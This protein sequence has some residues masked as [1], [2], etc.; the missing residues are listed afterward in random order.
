MK[1]CSLLLCF[2]CKTN[3]YFCLT[4]TNSVFNNYWNTVEWF[5]GFGCVHVYV[6]WINQSYI[7]V[8]KRNLRAMENHGNWVSSFN[9]I[10]QEIWEEEAS[11]IKWGCS[12]IGLSSYHEDYKLLGRSGDV[13]FCNTKLLL[14][15]STNLF[16]NKDPHR[17]TYCF[18]PA[19]N[20]WILPHS[21]YTAFTFEMIV[22]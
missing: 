5:L 6:G 2:D 18:L 15:L 1:F 22:E 11:D 8:C 17:S 20:L 19:S 16:W 14:L 21:T 10:D 12:K 7:Y 4:S 13:P 3:R 9:R